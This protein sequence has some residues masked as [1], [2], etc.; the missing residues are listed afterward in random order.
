MTV[1]LSDLQAGIINPIVPSFLFMM[2]SVI[3]VGRKRRTLKVSMC[4]TIMIRSSWKQTGL[5]S[6]VCT[7]AFETWY[8]QYYTFL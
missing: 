3:Y 1:V 6:I 5:Y 8:M 4:N 7:C 2:C